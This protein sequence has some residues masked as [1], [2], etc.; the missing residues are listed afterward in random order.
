MRLAK[1]AMPGAA[2]YGKVETW[3]GLRPATPGGAPIIGATR[4][5]NLWLNVGHGALGF[6]FAC[7]SAKLLAGAIRG[8]PAPFAL[9]DLY[10]SH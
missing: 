9:N 4:Y 7:G 8:E 2:D 5:G 10:R 3:A 1:E 6:T